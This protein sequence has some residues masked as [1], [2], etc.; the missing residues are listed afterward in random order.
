MIGIVVSYRLDGDLTSTYARIKIDDTS[1][2]HNRQGGEPKGRDFQTEEVDKGR[3]GFHG[4]DT[5]LLCLQYVTDALIIVR[6]LPPSGAFVFPYPG[7]D[8]KCNP[9]RFVSFIVLSN[10]LSRVPLGLLLGLFGPF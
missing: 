8:F 9:I 1:D 2:L 6:Q 4:S 3:S 5:S 10:Y 7:L